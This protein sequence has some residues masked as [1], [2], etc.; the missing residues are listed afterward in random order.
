MTG[1][2]GWKLKCVWLGSG[3]QFGHKLEQTIKLIFKDN[4]GEKKEVNRKERQAAG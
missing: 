1:A 3:V 4:E 2:G